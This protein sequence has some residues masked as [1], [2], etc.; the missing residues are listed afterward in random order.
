MMLY[1]DFIWFS[2]S[3]F[4]FRAS[5]LLAVVAFV[6]NEEFENEQRDPKYEEE[7]EE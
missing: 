6:D 5:C 4:Y 2:C 1:L 3:L 7:C